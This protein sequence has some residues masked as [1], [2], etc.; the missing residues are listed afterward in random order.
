MTSRRLAYLLSFCLGAF[1]VTATA[2]V[3]AETLSPDL[4]GLWMAVG[5]SPGEGSVQPIRFPTLPPYTELGQQRWDAYVAEFDPVVDDPAKFC[6]H[7]GMPGSMI[8]T[9]TFPMEMFHRP[10]DLTMMIEAYYQYRKIYIEGHDRPEP[11]LPTRM[12]YSVGRW[13]GDV[14]VVETT[15]LSERTLGRILMSEDARITE[16]MRVVTDVNGNRLLVDDITFV[17]PQMYTAPITMRGVWSHSPDTPI[18]EYVCS[19]NIFDEYI[20]NKRR[21]AKAD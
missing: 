3:R 21:E 1:V 5:R 15:H 13:E 7:P 11:I 12:G 8:G 10:N 4:N 19:Q 14:L 6:V 20:E 18:M 16:R 9:P 17:D 2:L